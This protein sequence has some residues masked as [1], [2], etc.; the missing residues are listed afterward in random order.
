MTKITSVTAGGISAL[1]L[2][3]VVYKVRTIEVLY[4][5]GR[6]NFLQMTYVSKDRRWLYGADTLTTLQLH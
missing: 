2:F 6:Y 4:K 5:L 3:G 1:K